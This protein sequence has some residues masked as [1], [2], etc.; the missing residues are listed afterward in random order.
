LEA[1]IRLRPVTFF[2]KQD[3]PRGLPSNEENIGF[4]AQEVR[5]VFP[6]AV[7]EGPDGY[8]DFNMHPVNVA[9]V[10]MVKELRAENEVLREEIR[11]IKARLGM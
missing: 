11:Q 8:L 9:L 5:K 4:I 10:N 3:N 7:S 1:I 6:E 2:Y